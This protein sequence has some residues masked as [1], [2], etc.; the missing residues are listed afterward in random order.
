MASFATTPDTVLRSA[1]PGDAPLLALLF[2]QSRAVE[3]AALP[4]DGIRAQFASMQQAARDAQYAQAYP[5]AESLIISDSAAGAIGRLLVDWSPERVRVVDVAVLA[6]HRGRG[7]GSAAIAGLLRRADAAGLPVTLRLL[8]ANDAAHR[9]YSR[10]GFV[11]CVD[12]DSTEGSAHRGMRR[13]GRPRR[14]PG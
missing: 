5:M 2:A 7:H 9:L 4:D 10:L 13:P 11:D 8:R 12:G 1:T 3:L 14:T 6:A